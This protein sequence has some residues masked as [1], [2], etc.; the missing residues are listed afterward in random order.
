MK[1]AGYSVDMST[2]ACQNMTYFVNDKWDNF[3]EL[4]G[5]P[6]TT[7]TKVKIKLKITNKYNV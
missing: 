3:F 4:N 6:P 2:S 1:P 5:T 7:K